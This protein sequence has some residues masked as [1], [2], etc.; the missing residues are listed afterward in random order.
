M[1]KLLI[2]ANPFPPMASAGSARLLRFLR[3]L[4]EHGWQATVL[5]PRA[6]G[7]EPV[8]PGVRVVRCAAPNLE[9]LYA[10]A[11]H[12]LATKERL[13]R[14][15]RPGG[16][17][18]GGPAGGAPA[19]DEPAG[20]E[21]A[22]S[23]PAGSA[24]VGSGP[25]AQPQAAR[26]P[27]SAAVNDWLALPDAYL[28][29]VLPAVHCGGRLVGGE[30]FD[31][32]LSSSP[33]PSVHLIAAELSRR[34]GLPWLADYRDPW[35]TNQF[36]HYPT[37]WHEAGDARL[38]RHALRR[39]TALTAVNQPMLDVLVS[40]HPQLAGC[41]HVLPNGFDPDEAA[42]DVTLG[43]G[44]W[45]VHT[46][47]LYGR[48][49]QT[50]AF[51][52][53][54]ATLPEDVHVLFVGAAGGRLGAEAAALGVSERVRIELYALHALALGYQRAADA[55]L[56]V[57]GR[58]PESMSSKVYEYLASRRPVF[59]ISPAGSAARSLFA[60]VGGAQC[61]L[62]DDDMAAPLAAFVASV[63]A[64]MIAV[65]DEASL[66]RFDAGALT[67]QLATLLDGITT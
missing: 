64:G 38:E 61:V 63:R 36:R 11:R 14:R 32:L 21:P 29:W 10:A 56:L 52:R 13:V 40:R 65:A 67:R 50:S 39:A 12:A 8:P 7:P 16:A 34:H 59:A 22:G 41:A 26:R 48:E 30:H 18:A 58:R 54:F 15:H 66:A 51:L 25:A 23:E 62:P 33:R 35:T 43:P 9:S 57:N 6:Q 5:A 1:K 42:A 2:V 31:A 24:S 4:P 44:F 46:G 28:G 37:A 3:H 45:L 55:L 19:G 17:A 47:R 20:N 27:R 53:A 49:Q 60:E